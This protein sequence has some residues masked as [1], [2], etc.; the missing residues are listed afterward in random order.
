LAGVLGT[1]FETGA[2][3]SNVAAMG[4]KRPA[5]VE[6]GEGRDLLAGRDRAL[7]ATCLAFN[8]RSIA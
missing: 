1:L 3:C 4:W 5:W 7:I 6:R 2:N 8:V